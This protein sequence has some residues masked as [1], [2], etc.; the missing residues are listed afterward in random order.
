MKLTRL[1]NG[2]EL[3][4]LRAELLRQRLLVRLRL[5][6]LG[7]Q[8]LGEGGLTHEHRELG[9]QLI[10]VLGTEPMGVVEH[11]RSRVV[12]EET[13][14]VSLVGLVESLLVAQ[15]VVFL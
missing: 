4:Q 13:H 2:D 9:V 14:A 11:S 5:R 12:D 3:T 8:L 1:Q 15:D 6:R 7:Q 10:L